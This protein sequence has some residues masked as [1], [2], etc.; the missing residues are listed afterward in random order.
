MSEKNI[1]IIRHGETS[2]NNKGYLQGATINSSLN[3]TG[4]KQAKAFFEKYK[5]IKFDKIYTSELLRS[6][7]SIDCFR[8]EGITVESY[9]ELNEIN[10][11]ILEGKKISPRA[12]MRLKRLAT[13]W[14]K[15]EYSK[16]IPGGESP[17][18]V[19]TRQDTFIKIILSRNDENNILISMHGR[20][21]RIFICKLLNEELSNM[22]K[23]RH[24]NLGLYVIK[25]TN[26][27]NPELLTYNSTEHLNCI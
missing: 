19:A 20:A 13:K 8:R 16:K 26:N 1:F 7:E 27:Q 12:W 5:D 4:K 15:G 14:K 2:Y 9:L 11:G 22:E 10:W 25:M 18:D 21:M 6:I 24:D 17:F 3:K 23:Y